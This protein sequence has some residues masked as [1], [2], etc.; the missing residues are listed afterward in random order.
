M[1]KILIIDDD[2]FM[3]MLYDFEL[4]EAGYQVSTIAEGSGMMDKIDLERPDLVVLDVKLREEDGLDLLQEIR[5]KFYHLPVI[6]CSAYP[7]YKYDSRT[8][9]ADYYVVKDSNLEELKQRIKMALEGGES[10]QAEKGPDCLDRLNDT[11][12]ETPAIP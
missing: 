3:R 6:L 5:N 10:F 11:F 9:S 1:K 2:K 8:M 4:S 12:E 7:I